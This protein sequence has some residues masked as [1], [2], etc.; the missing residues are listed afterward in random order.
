MLVDSDRGAQSGYLK[1]T[2]F[3]NIA[4]LGQMSSLKTLLEFGDS[5]MSTKT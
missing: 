4:C 3:L 5:K 2:H 1:V